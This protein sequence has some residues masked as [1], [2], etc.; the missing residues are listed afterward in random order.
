MNKS[1]LTKLLD[2]FSNGIREEEKELYKRVINENGIKQFNRYD[3]FYLA[4]IYPFEQF[5]NGFIASEVSG[6]QDVIFLLTHS[7]FVERQFEQ[8]IKVYE[9]SACHCDKSR[10]I[11]SSLI[12]FYKTGK[13]IEFDYNGEYTFHL[14]KKVFKTHESIVE[15]YDGV[16]SLYYGS[17]AMYLTAILNLQASQIQETTNAST[18]D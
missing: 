4:V 17:N 12:E 10:T 7:D 16:K 14:P 18:G 9:G 11:I 13:R 2:V 1:D 8:Y 15:F 6:N 5:L 3:E